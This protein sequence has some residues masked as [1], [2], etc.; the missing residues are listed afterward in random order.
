ML[1]CC[2]VA[3]AAPA[4]ALAERGFPKLAMWSPDLTHQPLADVARYDYL[5]M[6]DPSKIAALKALDPTIDLLRYTNACELPCKA[7]APADPAN[8]RLRA[9]PA[10]WILTQVG[11]NLTAP[12]DASTRTFPVASVSRNGL[13]LFKVGEVTVIDD[14][15][16]LVTAVGGDSI[17]V[18]RGVIR[19][20]TAHA[21]GVR[22]AAAATMWPGTV[23]MDLTA[24]CPQV[25]V[26]TQVGPEDW[27]HY[28]ARV[29]G[30]LLGEAAWDGLFVDRSDPNESWIVDKGF[31]RS[32]DA[33]RTNTFPSD[34]YAAFDSAWNAGMTGYLDG[35][36]AL[37]GDHL[38][39]GN[40]SVA[41]YSAL[42]GIE[43]EA[44]PRASTTLQDWHG[45]VIG[46]RGQYG[47]KGSLLEWAARS[48]APHLTT[49]E[50]KQFDDSEPA[51]WETTYMPD[52][53]KMRFGLCSALVGGSY[54]TYNIPIPRGFDGREAIWFDEYDGAGI[55]QGY[56]GQPLGLPTQVAPD[57]WRRDF[58]G[59]SALVNPTGA[60]ASVDLGGPLRK[61]RGAQVPSINNGAII[62]AVTIPARDG[63]VLLR[64][65]AIVGPPAPVAP[66]TTTLVRGYT[67]A[68]TRTDAASSTLVRLETPTASGWAVVATTTPAADGSFRF[69]VTPR[70]NTRYRA[71]VV[72]GASQASS[73]ETT[74]LVRVGIGRIGLPRHIYAYVRFT[75]VGLVFPAVD[76]AV[77]LCIYRAGAKGAW[78]WYATV[79][80]ATGSTGAWSTRIRLGH[81]TWRLVAM[82]ARK[83]RA[84]SSSKP[85]DFAF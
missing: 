65:L 52:Y 7:T 80:T 21:A 24:A 48:L 44:F 17:T 37:A 82:D 54:Y 53:R 15:V 60:S 76:P 85:R 49:V 84:P 19:P 39:Q 29:G 75:A 33:D 4:A 57:V 59:G 22:V 74:V 58:Q 51:G 66:G 12:V 42:N 32:I 10:S 1:A 77:N 50:T 43:L 72:N 63:I 40:Q 8:A 38:V 2:I 6:T 23:I 73:P 25:T 31:S 9:V 36:H 14:E 20:A 35:L 34:D 71:T 5:V 28:D 56:L 26:D 70:V 78:R 64:S 68:A 30:A 16:V 67:S 62:T 41:D 83:D 27:A 3:S 55:G 47:E 18:T 69:N 45:F 61:I 79:P 46:P 13:S 11:T 81:G